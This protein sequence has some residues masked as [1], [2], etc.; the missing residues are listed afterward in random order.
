LKPEQLGKPSIR[1]EGDVAKALP[2][3]GDNVW[4]LTN[5]VAVEQR[6]IKT[7]WAT[8]FFTKTVMTL[9]GPVTYYI[10]LL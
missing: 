6:H 4:C 10:L 3:H 8:D 7:L 5:V 9:K 1:R 2:A